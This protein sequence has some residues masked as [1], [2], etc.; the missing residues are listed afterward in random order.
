M[1]R[2]HNVGP[3]DT[4]GARVLLRPGHALLLLGVIA[5]GAICYPAIKVGLESAPAWR[6]AGLRTLLG[7]LFLLALLAAF[8]RPLWPRRELARWIVPLGLLAT[9]LTFGSMFL[10][11]AFTGAGI[12]AIL[13]NM[14]PLGVVVLAAAFLGERLNTRKIIA[15]A[16]GVGGIVLIAGPLV[17]EGNARELTGT[18][19]AA[20]SSMGAA[21]AS[22]LMKRL[23][24]GTDLLALSAWQLIAGSLP[25]LALSAV[26]EREAPISWS[27]SFVA[28]LVLLALTGTALATA[29]WFWLLQHYEAGPLSLY[30]F[31]APVFGLLIALVFRGETLSRS[32]TAGILLILTGLGASALWRPSRIQ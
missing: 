28:L 13:G 10:S 14:Q 2:K 1:N 25:L 20:L 24:P 16:L 22:V 4:A 11:P 8:K 18:M 32:E 23:S 26:A 5:A 6:F 3:K 31:L 19:L 21:G 27:P 15:L 30:L 7:G 9:T 12:G 17:V 29:G